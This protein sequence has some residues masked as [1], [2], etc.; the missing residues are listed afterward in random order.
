MARQVYT[1]T[2]IAATVVDASP[3]A[4]EVPLGYVA[5]VRDVSITLETAAND[6]GSFELTLAASPIVRWSW[7]KGYIGTLHWE[8]RHA[9][10]GL[11]F[12]VATTYALFV[13]SPLVI[14][15]GYLLTT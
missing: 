12:I 6:A 2:F 15:T 5:V 4:Y 11:T 10:A 13:S 3:V 14:V 8:G 9:T 7:P 1:T